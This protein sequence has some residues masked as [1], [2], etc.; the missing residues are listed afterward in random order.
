MY[1]KSIIF[2]IYSYLYSLGY[3]ILFLMH[4]I[5]LHSII[6]I[7]FLKESGGFS[8]SCWLTNILLI[9]AL[10][11]FFVDPDRRSF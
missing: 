8:G 6:I 5:V 11:H 7:D 4:F 2:A 9:V 10:V 3:C 1:Y